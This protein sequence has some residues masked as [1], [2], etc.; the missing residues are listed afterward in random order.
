MF[1]FF[2]RVFLLAACCSI[3]AISSFAQDPHYT[4]FYSNHQ[5]LNPA[6]SGAAGGPRVAMN[7]RAQWVAVP[8]S[9]RQMMFGYDQPFYFGES[10]SGGGILLQQDRAGE[11]N[12]KKLDMLLNYSFAIQMGGHNHEHYLRFGL[13]GGIQ[14]A[15]IDF[16]K[17]RFG[18]QIDPELGFIR[19]TQE[20]PVGTR[21][22]PDVNFGVGW[23]NKNAWTGVTVHHLTQPDQSWP[24]LGGNGGGDSKLPM[25]ITAVAGFNVEAGPMHDKDAIV[26]SPSVLYMKQK[27]FNQLALG[28]YTLLDPVVFGVWYRG[29]FNNFH[30]QFHQG[31]M[32]AGLVG[33]KEGIF[34]VGYSY[35]YT[36]SS[37]TNGISGGSHEIALIL[38]FESDKKRR[39]IH[40]RLTCPRF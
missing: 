16:H 18:D 27:N 26:L 5:W 34:S 22:Q 20:I 36:I 40:R 7:Y 25:R 17:L 37:L 38:E 31:D 32:I 19:A 8:G 12:L 35:D 21:L 10:V 28:F 1:R 2:P 4:Q 29:N 14:Q 9:Y 3:L 30:E 13:S 15:S 33:F 39:F 24:G 23:Y 6:F 11:G